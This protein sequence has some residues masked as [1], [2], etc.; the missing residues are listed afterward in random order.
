MNFTSLFKRDIARNMFYTNL[1][2]KNIVGCFEIKMV[3]EAN[4]DQLWAE[5][6]TRLCPF[7]FYTPSSYFILQILNEYALFSEFSLLLLQF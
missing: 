1:I 4:S 7:F 2:S 5:P 6:S 3:L